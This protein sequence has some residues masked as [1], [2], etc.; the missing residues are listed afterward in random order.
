MDEYYGYFAEISNLTEDLKDGLEYVHWYG[1]VK[2]DSILFIKPNFTYP[3][4]K[5]RITTTPK[6]LENLLGTLK[7]KAD[8]VIVRESDS[9]NRSF[10][11]DETSKGYNM[12]EIS[13]K[14]ACELI[15][16]SEIR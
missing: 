2:S 5:P 14:A 16:L 6:M 3:F 9:G 1:Y 13:N 4:H 15:N 12:Y 8:R 7:D 10:T 11:A